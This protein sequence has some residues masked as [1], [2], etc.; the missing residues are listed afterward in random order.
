MT[1]CYATMKYN[2]LKDWY[3]M[4]RYSDILLEE[5]EFEKYCEQHNTIYIKRCI[6]KA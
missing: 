5:K 4:E 3:D 6:L 1:K 2:I